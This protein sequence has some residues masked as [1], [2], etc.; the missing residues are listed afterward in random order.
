MSKIA[1][2]PPPPQVLLPLERT[3]TSVPLLLPDRPRA[4]LIPAKKPR[5]S[6]A[7]VELLPDD[8]S[9]SPEDDLELLLDEELELP[10][11]TKSTAM[12]ITLASVVTTTIAVSRS[13]LRR[14]YNS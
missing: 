7:D 10:S 8:F 11:N 13:A 14:L 2:P 6:P 9:L 5:R 4:E 12:M 3:D 1:G